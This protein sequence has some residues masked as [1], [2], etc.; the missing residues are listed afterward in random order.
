MHKA[1][2][3]EFQIEVGPKPAPAAAPVR[4]WMQVPASALI[5]DGQVTPLGEEI[6]TRLAARLL[7]VSQ[8]R[9][10][11]YCD[12]GVLRE[13]IDWRKN[14]SRGPNGMYHIRRESV[15]RMLNAKG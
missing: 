7:G 6:S 12:E 5:V 11:A 4:R 15:L 13:G 2:Q 14:P 8:R 10:Q 9:M 1:T 3:F